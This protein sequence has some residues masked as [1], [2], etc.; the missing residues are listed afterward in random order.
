MEHKD[1]K[2]LGFTLTELL[3]VVTVIALLGAVAI[4]SLITNHI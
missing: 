3:I 1:R 4:T 2:V